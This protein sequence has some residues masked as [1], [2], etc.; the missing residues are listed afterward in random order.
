LV[1]RVRP[2]FACQPPEAVGA[3]LADLTAIWLASHVVRGD[4]AETDALRGRLMFEQTQAVRALT[5]I[6]AQ[7]M[8]TD[9]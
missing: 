4:P 2:L 6:N 7:E 3:A 1:E 5:A 8:G 9:Q